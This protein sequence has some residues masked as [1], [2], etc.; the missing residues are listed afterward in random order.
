MEWVQ[1]A[2]YP[3]RYFEYFDMLANTV[4]AVLSGI[5]YFALKK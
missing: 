3:N 4:G 1:G 5:V 2:F